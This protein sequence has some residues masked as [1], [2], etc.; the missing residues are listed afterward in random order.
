[1]EK[2]AN[3]RRYLTL[4]LV[5]LLCIVIGTSL[6]YV[7]FDLSSSDNVIQT[8][9][10]TMSYTEPSNEIVLKDALPKKD[11]LGRVQNEYFEF[12]V[13]SNATT[14]EDDDKG[15][16]MEYEI[17]LS[18]T[19]IDLL[20]KP[21]TVNQIKVFLTE[22][23]GEEEITIIE[24]TL[25][26]NLE[27]SKYTNS[28]FK[29]HNTKNHHHNN[30]GTITTKYRLR[31][32][33]DYDVDATNWEKY[34]E[35]EYR[36]VVNVNG[37]A[38][39]SNSTTL[40]QTIKK[41]YTVDNKAA[42]IEKGVYYL[43]GPETAIES[44]SK[45]EQFLS[46]L[47]IVGNIYLY[48]N[49]DNTYNHELLDNDMYNYLINEGGISEEEYNSITSP[50]E[51]YLNALLGIVT[52][53]VNEEMQ[54]VDG[55]TINDIP[56]IEQVMND[57]N[58]KSSLIELMSSILPEV[59]KYSENSFLKMYK[60]ETKIDEKFLN[61][62]LELGIKALGLEYM[63]DIINTNFG[64]ISNYA[65]AEVLE[66]VEYNDDGIP[67]LS[68]GYSIETIPT[69]DEIF[70]G[71]E[72]EITLITNN[73]VKLNDTLYEVISINRDNSINLIAT[74]PIYKTISS[75]N[76]EELKEDKYFKYL[77][78]INDN[79]INYYNTIKGTSL[80]NII[81]LKNSNYRV[82]NRDYQKIAD[83]SY[84][85]YK[86]FIT[87]DE[88]QKTFNNK[89]SFINGNITTDG[90]YLYNSYT[91]NYSYLSYYISNTTKIN[92]LRQ[93]N[94]N[95]LL[96]A[97]TIEDIIIVG[98]GSKTDPFRIEE[99]KTITNEQIALDTKYYV[100][101]LENTYTGREKNKFNQSN[102]E[103]KYIDYINAN[104]SYFVKDT[105][106]NYSAVAINIDS[107]CYN[108]SNDNKIIRTNLT[109]TG[110]EIEL[111][112]YF[113]KHPTSIYTYSYNPTEFTVEGVN[114]TSYQ[115]QQKAGDEW[116]NLEDLTGRISGSKTNKL[117][118]IPTSYYDYTTE[119][120]CVI[121]NGKKSVA[122]P[123]VYMY[124]TLTD[125]EWVY[126]EI[127]DTN[128][129][130]II[131]YVGDHTNSSYFT[132]LEDGTNYHLEF[133]SVINGDTITKINSLAN[134]LSLPKTQ[135][136]NKAGEV[137]TSIEIPTGIENI[138]TYI[139]YYNGMEYVSKINN[140]ILNEGLIS[141]GRATNNYDSTNGGFRNAN[142]TEIK[143]PSTLK[144]IGADAFSKAQLTKLEI[145]EGVKD[146]GA[147]AFK[148]S[149]LT[150][151]ELPQTIETIGSNSFR[152]SQLKELEIPDSVKSIGEG[153]FYY[154]TLE[155]LVLNEG[156]ERIGNATLT[157]TVNSK[158]SEG[159]FYNAQLTKLELPDSLKEIGNAS[160]YLSPLKE[161]SLNENLEVIGHKAFYSSKIN[162]LILG[163]KLEYIGIKAFNN[164]QLINLEIPGNVKTIGAGAFYSSPL[165][166]L[167]INNGV[168]EIAGTYNDNSITYAAG[169]FANAKLTS[170]ELPDSLTSLGVKAFESSPLTSLKLSNNLTE[171]KNFTFRSSKLK[172]LE[173]PGSVKTIYQG[174]FQYAP[175]EE[176]ILHEG[177]EKIRTDGYTWY[178][179]SSNAVSPFANANLKSI[180]IPSTLWKIYSGVFTNEFEEVIAY[181]S[182][183]HDLSFKLKDG[184]SITY[185]EGTLE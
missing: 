140:I 163:K 38:E 97:I 139:D 135:T 2:L 95:E 155:T 26:K 168:Q 16:D 25:I 82:L 83:I 60:N 111:Y 110:C 157:N 86:R 103:I 133:P 98:N 149:V 29:I 113:K 93:S 71:K 31:F 153:A 8:G 72:E 152:N 120:R 69:V 11:E 91:N 185:M 57:E 102:K 4:L 27:K 47:G 6:S 7:L 147:G 132:L 1:M 145:P 177:I 169:A 142:I 45:T 48:R 39:K 104:N 112:P 61:D 28:T 156:L 32:W 13:M 49:R 165:T 66:Y 175:L 23:V 116:V 52:G 164:A 55:K 144:V 22:V 64:N 9:Q 75:E 33:V 180:K 160:F 122:G 18:E 131:G 54:Y 44:E 115:W 143:L 137:L 3:N 119:F 129:Y 159:A 88:I 105:T 182:N 62:N 94:S 92:E 181:G 73:Y 51:G 76:V 99:E 87:P 24:P 40:S 167:I 117:I 171:I 158:N 65:I 67:I 109:E 184:K 15:V 96:P 79:K 20:F 56:S 170:L 12:S 58:Q 130:Q 136:W 138:N 121:S 90:F 150:K 37:H 176:L 172:K 19:D 80:G 100:E 89:G 128:K 36:F 123:S 174:A 179:S 35:F 146:I 41:M 161:L 162:E 30:N 78:L 114:I 68:N 59:I 126:E 34:H 178:Q 125:G 5:A 81:K 183:N 118:I 151:L 53:V 85:G 154:S 141:I 173:I 108:V 42:N 17:S 148:S 107:Y 74:N 10:V 14:N 50:F 106:D 124:L 127:K 101:T 166:N 134:S 43:N 70:N 21:L 84:E 63:L 77:G 46:H